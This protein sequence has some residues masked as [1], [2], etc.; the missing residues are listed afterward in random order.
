MSL[1]YLHFDLSENTEGIV[2]FDAMASVP[3]RHLSAL[4]AEITR[5]LDWAHTTFPDGPAPTDEGAPWD[6]DL[7]ATQ[8][9]SVPDALHYDA[10]TRR[11]SSTPGGVETLRHTVTL[12]ISGTD[13]F[14][15]AF[16]AAFGVGE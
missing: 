8:E 3:P 1:H 14:G 16:R 13:T 6:Y 15:A 10:R 9:R 4:H 2:T 12:S 11:L 5:L 7:H